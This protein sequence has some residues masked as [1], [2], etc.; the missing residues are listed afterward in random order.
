MPIRFPLRKRG[1][2]SSITTSISMRAHYLQHVPFEGLGSIGPWLE[3]RGAHVT[4]T[5]LFEDPSM[6]R[7]V[8]FD[9]LI[10]MGGPMSANDDDRH[11][12]L[13]PERS[14]IAEAV[15]A[16]KVVLGVCLG[17][18]L[19]ARALGARVFRNAE[20]EIGWFPVE[21]LEGSSAAI[22]AEDG[23]ESGAPFSLPAEAFHWH[24]ETFDLPTGATHL[25]RSA[26]CAH[27]AFRVGSRVLGLQFHLEMTAAGA[28]ALIEACRAEIRPSRWIQSEAEM[29]R[30]TERF[31]RT[32]RA[33]VR[34]LDW[35]AELSP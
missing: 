25:A 3:S 7:T 15:G 2:T 8:D 4:A 13:A 28:R 11:P 5:R 33:M 19:L 29:V 24:G 26:A 34:V 16:G 10:V 14:L 22:S 31:E 35:L 9:W 27:Q 1:R 18:Q 12:W 23:L 20:T 21:S 30:D 6:P 32:N 17:A